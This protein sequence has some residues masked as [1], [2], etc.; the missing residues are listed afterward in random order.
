VHFFKKEKCPFLLNLKKA[1]K[2]REGK[3]MSVTEEK[4]L[5]GRTALEAFD[6]KPI[7]INIGMKTKKAQ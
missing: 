2:R 4:R 6:G 3:K 1:V 5:I 7:F